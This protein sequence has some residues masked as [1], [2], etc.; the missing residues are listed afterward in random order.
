MIQVPTPTMQK[1][2]LR[3]TYQR[4]K[5]FVKKLYEKLSMFYV[6][7]LQFFWTHY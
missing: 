1:R 4:W 2:F 7:S 6:K 3:L 5:V